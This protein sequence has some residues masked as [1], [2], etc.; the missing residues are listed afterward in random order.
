MKAHP[1]QRICA[2]LQGFKMIKNW[3]LH[4][5]EFGFLATQKEI[6][7]INLSEDVLLEQSYHAISANNR[8]V[9]D[10]I[11]P[12]IKVT[13][14]ILDEWVGLCIGYGPASK[15]DLQAHHLLSEFSDLLPIE[16]RGLSSAISKNNVGL[17]GLVLMCSTPNIHWAH[18]LRLAIID[19]NDFFQDVL[20]EIC[21]EKIVN[22][23]FSSL[24]NPFYLNC[25]QAK[26]S[27]HDQQ[28]IAAHTPLI[29]QAHKTLR[30]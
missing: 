4:A 22:D 2:H 18:A 20:M 8:L 14:Q 11:K 15:T 9:F 3:S 17:F 30:L 21:P 1:I 24:S 13:P 19:Q 23:L 28:E 12:K 10:W 7:H 5:E 26:K 6:S 25:Y 29:H 16:G 27:N